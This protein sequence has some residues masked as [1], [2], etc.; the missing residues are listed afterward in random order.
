MG[1][2][3]PEDATE[4]EACLKGAD[5]IRIRR[6]AIVHSIYMKAESG[7]GMEA[8]KPVRKSLGY[9]AKPITVEE[10]EALADEVTVLRSD[11]FR[12]GWNAGAGKQPGMGLIPGSVMNQV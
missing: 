9:N 8:L 10:M 7:E 12:V 6:N 1:I 11:L 5:N 4:I 3:A 2:V